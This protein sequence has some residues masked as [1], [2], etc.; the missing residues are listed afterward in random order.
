MDQIPVPISD[1]TAEQ[2]RQACII[3]GRRN[4]SG[5][6]KGGAGGTNGYQN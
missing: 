2:P 5:E 3:S 6:V 4:S 1:G